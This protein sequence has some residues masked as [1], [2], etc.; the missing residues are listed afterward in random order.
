MHQQQ[1]QA[2][3]STNGQR[4]QISNQS[5]SSATVAAVSAK[6]PHFIAVVTLLVMMMIMMT[7]N[8][9]RHLTECS[10]IVNGYLNPWEIPFRHHQQSAV[11][12]RDPMPWEDGYF[13]PSYH[14]WPKSG[15][16]GQQQ[17]VS[18]NDKQSASKLMTDDESSSQ[19]QHQQANG[20][21]GNQVQRSIAKNLAS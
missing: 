17:Q 18:A 15:H 10:P 2:T 21:F 8:Q 12:L 13:D 16:R 5:M 20:Q 14:A 4:R 9:G 6:L 3:T 11:A 1:R 19:Q 7:M